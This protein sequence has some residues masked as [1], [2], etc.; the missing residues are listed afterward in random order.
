M[1]SLVVE[2]VVVVVGVGLFCLDRN[3]GVDIG[4]CCPGESRCS[5]HRCA[6]QC[7]VLV[8]DENEELSSLLLKRIPFACSQAGSGMMRICFSLLIWT[9]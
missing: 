7:C 4:R 8:G 2:G 5:R 9:R 6:L 3:R 1:Y